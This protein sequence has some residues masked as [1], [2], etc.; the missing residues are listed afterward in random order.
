MI[1]SPTTIGEHC[2]VSDAFFRLRKSESAVDRKASDKLKRRESYV[3][4]VKIIKDPQ[5]PELEGTY[6]IFKFGY[7]I[8]EKID[9]ELKPNFGEPTQVFD[10]FE[11]KNFELVITRQND[12]NNYDTSKFSSSTSAVTVKGKAAERTKED[13]DAIKTELEGAP[14]M[15]QFEYRPWDEDTRNFVNSVL[16]MYLNPGEAIDAVTNQFETS[17][18]VP[19]AEKATSTPKAEKATSTPKAEKEATPA[20][21][22]DL[23]SFLNDLEL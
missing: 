8:K 5:Q 23:E 1:D 18:P 17:T 10:L 9:A 12:Y 22:D 15:K 2:P 11:G 4:L 21:G 20:G 14:S 16:K 19:K 13:M 6:K 7:K 3:A